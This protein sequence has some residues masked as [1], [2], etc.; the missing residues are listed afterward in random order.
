MLFSD[1]E[2][3]SNY[4]ERIKRLLKPG[5]ILAIDNTLWSGNV[6]D[7]KVKDEETEAIRALNSVVAQDRSV[8]V[9]FL[10]I[11]DGLA[12]VFKPSDANY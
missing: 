8:N 4:Y 1:K 3:Y 12:L 5:G 11:A 6:V 7:P 10:N 2:N 9:S